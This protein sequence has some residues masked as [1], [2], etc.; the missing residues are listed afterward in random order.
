MAFLPIVE[1]KKEAARAGPLFN[2]TVAIR[3][4][5]KA[6]EGSGAGRHPTDARSVFHFEGCQGNHHCM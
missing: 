1:E 3:D 5:P 6:P 4:A 2:A